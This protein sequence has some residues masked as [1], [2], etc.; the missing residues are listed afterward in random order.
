MLGLI[1][2]IFPTVTEAAFF[3][4]L[5]GQFLILQKEVSY[6]RDLPPTATIEQVM[7]DNGGWVAQSEKPFQLTLD[8]I[9]LWVRFERCVGVFLRW[10]PGSCAGAIG[11][12]LLHP[13]GV[14]GRD[15]PRRR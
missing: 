10:S 2:L 1:S 13:T 3:L 11:Q 14:G 8:P 15:P 5:E 9:D 6:R 12:H 7:A 4:R